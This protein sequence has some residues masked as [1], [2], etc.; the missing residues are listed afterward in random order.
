MDEDFIRIHARCAERFDPSAPS[1]AM[2]SGRYRFLSNFWACNGI[3]VAGEWYPTVEHAYQASK[4]ARAADR[5][6][7]RCAAT[8][9][10]AKQFGG[11]VTRMQSWDIV[12]LSVML[13]LLRMKFSDANP[14][15]WRALLDT[16]EAELIEG[17]H[18]HDHFWGVCR[19]EGQNHLG[20]L[21]MRVRDEMRL[22]GMD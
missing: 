16:G 17:N 11:L 3:A 13:S 15:L 6:M 4:C 20:R 10:I 8:P 9:G 21:L 12:R 2:F 7:I 22:E 19:G 5:Q 18:W 14:D 1:I